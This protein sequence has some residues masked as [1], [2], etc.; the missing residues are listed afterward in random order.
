MAWSAHKTNLPRTK[1]EGGMN[2]IAAEKDPPVPRIPPVVRV[3][4]V[5]VQPA[6]VLVVIDVEDIEIAIRVR[7]Y[8]KP[9]NTPPVE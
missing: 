5:R 6:T 2:R 1:V 9:S 7:I 8:R 3:T 4:V